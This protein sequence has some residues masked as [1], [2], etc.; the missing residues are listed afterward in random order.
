MKKKVHVDTVGLLKDIIIKYEGRKT[1][2]R[3]KLY[4]AE[5]GVV[6]HCKCKER[7]RSNCYNR[8]K[9]TESIAK[10]IQVPHRPKQIQIC[11]SLKKLVYH[12][13]SELDL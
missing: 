5:E 12:D 9:H 8:N 2:G 11:N 6:A 13:E 4:G 3:D 1:Y 10:A 7:G